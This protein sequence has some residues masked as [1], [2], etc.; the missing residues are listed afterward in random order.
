M[1]ESAPAAEDWSPSPHQLVL[2][3]ARRRLDRRRRLMSTVVTLVVLG[4][5]VAGV[6][7]SPG[8]PRVRDYFLSWHQARGSFHSITVGFWVNIRI[9]LIAEPSVLILGAAVAVV[10]QSKTPW[11]APLRLL[12]VVYADLL[13]G[14]PSLLVLAVVAVGVPALQ[15][16]GV[17]SSPFWLATVAL[18]LCYTAYVSEVLRAGILA[19][20]PTQRA[21]ADALGLSSGQTLFH[22]VLPQAVRRVVPPLMNDLVSLQ[23]DTSLVSTVG[24][25]DA[26]NAANDWQSYQFNGTSLVV[27]SL[28]FLVIAVPLTRLTDWLLMRQIRREQ[29]A[30]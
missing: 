20:H 10:R 24:V 29:G 6:L 5:V 11:L 1:T 16:E 30:L 19:I 22:V 2:A 27:A 7:V 4:A 8:W 12:A 3:G 26:M 28:Y 17:P 13:R 14:V 23:K 15:L 25:W 18:V 21:S 9:F